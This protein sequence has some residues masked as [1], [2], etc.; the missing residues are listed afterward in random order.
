M[1][2]GYNNG[3]FIETGKMSVSVDN[4]GIN[5][6]YGAFDFFGVINHNPFYLER[7]LDRFMRTIELLR[8]EISCNRNEIQSLIEETIHRNSVSDFQIKLFAL[9]LLP[10]S[11]GSLKSGL[12]ILPVKVAHYDDELYSKGARLITKNYTRFLPEA[13]S[14]NYLPM[15]F[16]YAELLEQ[17]ATDVLYLTGHV[18]RETSRAN[19]FV[20]KNGTVFTPG[21]GMLKGITRSIVFDILSG[22][23]IQLVTDE[24]LINDLLN[25]DEIFISSTTKK[26]MPVVEINGEKIGGGSVGQITKRIM[27]EFELIQKDFGTRD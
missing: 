26:I 18:V 4:L 21:E 25:A 2:T 13:K 9:P 17:Q 19:I 14:T 1:F 11:A 7:H 23:S 20:V 27:E 15:V 5:R 10:D 12:Y 3:Q 24:L 6:G 22:L 16:W 8:L